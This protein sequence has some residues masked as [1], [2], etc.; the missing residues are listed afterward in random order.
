MNTILAIFAVTVL[1]YIVVY[2]VLIGIVVY[3]IRKYRCKLCGTWFSLHFHQEWHDREEFERGYWIKYEWCHKCY[4]Y[5]INEV[6]EN[7][8]IYKNPTEINRCPLWIT[9]KHESES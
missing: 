4:Q 5:H 9:R 6:H 8:I 2:F 1:I 3:F 7:G